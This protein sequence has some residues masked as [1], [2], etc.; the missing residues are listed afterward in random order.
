MEALLT[1]LSPE[2]NLAR[3]N[4]TLDRA[5]GYVGVATVMGSRFTVSEEALTPVL[6][7]LKELGLIF[8]DNQSSPESIAWRLAATMGVPNALN[9]RTLD[10][11]QANRVAIDACL[12]QLEGIARAEGFA[13]AMGRPYPVT[14]TRLREWAK[15]LS[16][17]GFVLAPISAVVERQRYHLGITQVTDK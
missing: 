17:R 13:V 11:G 8:I 5:R 9:D 14:I 7:A 2:Q 4:W 10:T 3:L 15:G 12:V 1:A 6:K 16:E